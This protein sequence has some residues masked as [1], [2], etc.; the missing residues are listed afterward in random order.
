VASSAKLV[1]SKSEARRLSETGGLYVNNK[2]VAD[3]KA[4]IQES[5]VV[6]SKVVLL[7]SG[8]K[9]YKLVILKDGEAQ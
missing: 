4:V 2:A 7:R 6:D 9:N 3:S 8:K 1:A 5:D